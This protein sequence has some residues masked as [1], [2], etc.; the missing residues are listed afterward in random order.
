MCLTCLEI[1]RRHIRY[2]FRCA[3]LSVFPPPHQ[4]NPP[5]PSPPRLNALVGADSGGVTGVGE[6]KGRPSRGT[7]TWL[8]AGEQGAA[9]NSCDGLCSAAWRRLC[10][11]CFVDGGASTGAI[12]RNT[13]HALAQPSRYNRCSLGLL[14]RKAGGRG[15]GNA[16]LIPLP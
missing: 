3:R 15:H 4:F 8:F 12:P 10:R 2:V 9:A 11:G 7:P 13:C 5:F 6:W 1:W 14:P 16:S